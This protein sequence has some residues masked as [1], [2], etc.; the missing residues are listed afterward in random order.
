MMCCVYDWRKCIF[1]GVWLSNWNLE[2]SSQVCDKVP[3][4]NLSIHPSIHPSIHCSIHTLVQ[5]NQDTRIYAAI[6]FS[7]FYVVLGAIRNGFVQVECCLTQEA[8]SRFRTVRVFVK[9]FQ[10][11]SHSCL[12]LLL[13]HSGTSVKGSRTNGRKCSDF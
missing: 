8:F 6:I 1:R 9:C 12:V 7:L 2:H 3:C 13:Q 11:R 4:R 5:R 10:S